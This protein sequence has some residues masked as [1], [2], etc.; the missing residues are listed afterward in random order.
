MPT[1]KIDYSALDAALLASLRSGKKRFSALTADGAGAIARALDPALDEK[2]ESFRLVDRRLQALRRAG[3]CSYI[4]KTG[5]S[6]AP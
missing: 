4:T 5:W 2:G 6:I 3:R 1:K